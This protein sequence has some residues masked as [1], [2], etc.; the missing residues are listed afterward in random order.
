MP[1]DK[2]R[3]LDFL[4]LITIEITCDSPAYSAFV[5]IQ[6]ASTPSSSSASFSG[7]LALLA[8]EN[9]G[10]GTYRYAWYG[11]HGTRGPVRVPA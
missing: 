6:P 2:T 5:S 10:N 8:M 4:S 3:L 11:T 9:L 1:L 7:A